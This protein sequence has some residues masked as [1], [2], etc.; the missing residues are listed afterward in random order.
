MVSYSDPVNHVSG[1]ICIIRWL[2]FLCD[3]LCF[4]QFLNCNIPD[5]TKVDD[6]NINKT[7]FPME[8]S[9]ELESSVIFSS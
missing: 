2:S 8:I 3:I 4:G 1:N 5:I 7:P 6:N 9:T